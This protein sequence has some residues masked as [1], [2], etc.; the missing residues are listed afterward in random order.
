MERQANTDYHA[1]R[2]RLAA[3]AGNAI[4][5]LFAST[6]EEGQNSTRGFRQGDDFYYLTGWSEPGAALLIA[7]KTEKREYTEVFFLPGRN[8]SQ[9]RWTGPKAVADTNGIAGITGFDRVLPLDAMRDELVRIL[10]SPAVRILTDISEQGTTPATVPLTWLSRANAFPNYV[11]YGD[12]KEMIAEL[13]VTKDEGELALLRK[14]A[15]STVEGHR[16]AMRELRP[17]KSENEIAA[18]IEYEYRRRG[19]EA[20]A[21]SSIVGSGLNSTVLH[22]AAND[23]TIADG[24]LVV[25]D[26]GGEYSMYAADVT[27]TLPANG[28][29]TARQREIY[30]IV[31]GAQKAAVDAFKSGVSTINRTSENSLY[32]V[33]MDYINA[34]GKDLHGEPLGKY[35]IHGLSHFVGL[36]VHDAGDGAKPLGPGAVF[37]IEPG[38]YIT[39]EKLGVRIEDTYAV[40]ADGTLECISCGAIKDAAAIEKAMAARPK[41]EKK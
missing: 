5:V 27:R 41:A 6:E 37:T 38:I 14:A 31:L 3:K 16:A 9:E 35:F 34:H 24:D 25:M 30:D 29:F 19:C 26:V 36:A 11:S 18:L 39:E 20:P 7:P 4:V 28:H 17:G 13:R 33:A 10:P 1:R 2:E 40:R 8:V 15:E 32:K 12:V 23:G 22:Y 21:F